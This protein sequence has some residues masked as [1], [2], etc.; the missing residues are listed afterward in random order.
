MMSEYPDLVNIPFNNVFI[1]DR[2]IPGVPRYSSHQLEPGYW[3]II[4]DNN[5]ILKATLIISICRKQ[6]NNNNWSN[7]ERLNIPANRF[8][9]LWQPLTI[10]IQY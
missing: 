1:R 7:G 8:D 4:Q 3:V 10:V 9:K 2:F 6:V 5:V